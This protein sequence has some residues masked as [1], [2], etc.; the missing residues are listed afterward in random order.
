VSDK[1][2]TVTLTSFRLE[3]AHQLIDRHHIAENL[4]NKEMVKS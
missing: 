4:Q 2:E 3:K 1:V